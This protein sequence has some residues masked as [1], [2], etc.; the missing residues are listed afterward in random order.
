M[1]VTVWTLA[2]DDDNGTQ[3]AIF[4]TEH[5]AQSAF[6]NVVFSDNEEAGS[7]KKAKAALNAGDYDELHDIAQRYLEGSL[8]TYNIDEHTIEVS[9]APVKAVVVLEGGL[10]RDVVSTIPLSVAVI[11]YDTEDAEDADIKRIPQGAGKFEDG[12]GH[13]SKAYVL[14]ERCEELYKAIDDETEQERSTREG[15]E[16]ITEMPFACKGCGREESI[17]SADPCDAVIAD[18]AATVAQCVPEAAL[19]AEPNELPSDP[20]D[21]N[22]ERAYWA[23]ETLDYFTRTHGEEEGGRQQNLV[24]LLADLAHYC[25]RNE[26]SF[27]SCLESARNHYCEET[28]NTGTQ[29]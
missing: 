19:K 20:E 15:I 10:V 23:G 27:E 8:D 24:D 13:I 2:S 1:K 16:A 29:L 14:P 5:E 11:D 9:G 7:A 12:T 22:D 28:D 6:W 4:S 17:C 3:T 18:R 21:M 26:L 25:D